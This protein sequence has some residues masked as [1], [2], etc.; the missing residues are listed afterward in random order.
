MDGFRESKAPQWECVKRAATRIIR[1]ATCCFVSFVLFCS[2]L[3]YTRHRET[4]GNEVNK[5]C[6]NS[7]FFC[8]EAV[9]RRQTNTSPLAKGGRV[10]EC[11]MRSPQCGVRNAEWESS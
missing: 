11:G 10:M 3:V 2:R 5:D 1:N 8:T 6:P 7:L 4:E 9:Q